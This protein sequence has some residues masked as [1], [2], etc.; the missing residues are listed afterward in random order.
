[1]PTH[2]KYNVQEEAEAEINFMYD[3]HRKKERKKERKNPL[4]TNP[5]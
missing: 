1:M 5:H 4:Q 2:Q 3:T